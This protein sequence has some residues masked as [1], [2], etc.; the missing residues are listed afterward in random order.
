MRVNTAVLKDT[1]V[2]FWGIACLTA[3]LAVFYILGINQTV[4]N[5]AERQILETE[6]SSISNKIAELEFSYI[7]LKNNITINTA[8]ELGF[9]QVKEVVYVSRKPAVAF[10][11]TF[12]QT[13]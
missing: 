8:F 1:R 5:V 2:I 6:L 9:E 10:A 13:P 7:A 4:R 3:G 12:P 11:S